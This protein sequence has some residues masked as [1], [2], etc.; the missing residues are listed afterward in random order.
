MEPSIPLPTTHP[1]TTWRGHQIQV[2]PSSDQFGTN[3]QSKT[4]KNILKTS[5]I[6]TTGPNDNNTSTGTNSSSDDSK[7]DLSQP[8]PKILKRGEPLPTNDNPDKTSNNPRPPKKMAIDPT[9]NS[10]H[11]VHF[12]TNQQSTFPHMNNLHR[13]NL[14]YQQGQ[15][16]QENISH[17][18][19]CNN[20]HQVTIKE[21]HPTMHLPLQA[22]S[23]IL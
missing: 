19:K 11:N 8:P 13:Q 18:H 4:L 21:D 10:R 7:L 14:Y 9:S 2:P 23:S 5:S 20:L 12:H 3:A 22:I 17:P 6:A 15:T 16:P 1:Q